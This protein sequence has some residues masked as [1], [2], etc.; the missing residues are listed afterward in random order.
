MYTMKVIRIGKESA[1][2]HPTPSR[3]SVR[4][5]RIFDGTKPGVWTVGRW[6][7]HWAASAHGGGECSGLWGGVGPELGVFIFTCHLCGTDEFYFISLPFQFGDPV[8]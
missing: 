5:W 6:Q 8:I 1:R 7:N 2:E 3:L 4:Y